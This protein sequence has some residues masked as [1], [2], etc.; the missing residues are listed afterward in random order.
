MDLEVSLSHLTRGV[1]GTAFNFV[2][3]VIIR[4][5]YIRFGAF[6]HAC[7][8][9]LRINFEK[10]FIVERIRLR[11]VKLVLDEIDVFKHCK[12]KCF[13]YN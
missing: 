10:S 7:G 6:R 2:I 11:V 5:S 8:V 12:P 13:Y 1:R 4:K 9:E 3:I